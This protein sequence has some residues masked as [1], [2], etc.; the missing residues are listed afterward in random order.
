[1][2]SGSFC[3]NVHKCGECRW[4]KKETRGSTFRSVSSIFW[5]IEGRSGF[6]FTFCF[7]LVCIGSGVVIVG[8]NNNQCGGPLS[9]HVR[10]SV[11]VRVCICV[12]DLA[13]KREHTKSG[14]KKRDFL[15]SVFIYFV[16][17]YFYYI[18]SSRLPSSGITEV[19]TICCC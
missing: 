4:I 8:L 6:S 16:H 7:W 13:R 15:V 2:F 11:C 18:V 19:S 14:K 12:P 3:M 5:K 9:L 17:I 1:M 10:S